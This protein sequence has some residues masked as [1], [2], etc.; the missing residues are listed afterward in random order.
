VTYFNLS[1]INSHIIILHR[2]AILCAVLVRGFLRAKRRMTILLREQQGNGNI[3][4]NGAR[5]REMEH[6]NGRSLLPGGVQS[7]SWNW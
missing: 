2:S 4:R 3:V 7:V 5:R 6:G 1:V